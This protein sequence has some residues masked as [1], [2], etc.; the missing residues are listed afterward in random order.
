MSKKNQS[1]SKRIKNQDQKLVEPNNYL[2]TQRS[3]K[4]WYNISGMGKQRGKPRAVPKSIKKP[5]GQK[6][7]SLRKEK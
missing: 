2:E 7:H 3:H 5:S 4:N 6:K 1:D